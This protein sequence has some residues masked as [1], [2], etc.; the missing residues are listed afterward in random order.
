MAGGQQFCVAGIQQFV[1]LQ[2][3][4]EAQQISGGGVA[5]ASRRPSKRGSS[6]IGMPGLSSPFRITKGQIRHR[7]VS[8][9][10]KRGGSHP[11]R[12]VDVIAYVVIVVLA[13][14]FVDHDPQNNETIVT[15]FK[16]AT[17]LKPGRTVA[18]ETDVVLMRAQLSVVSVK[19]RAEK[20]S[21]AAGV[22]QQFA[23]RYLRRDLFIRIVR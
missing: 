16:S 17:R 8:R 9:L 23:N 10:R 12:N 6:S 18:K 15:V 14:Y 21:R 7:L 5:A 13:T 4:R 22:A 19:L 3:V 2:C 20:I 1:P 11:S